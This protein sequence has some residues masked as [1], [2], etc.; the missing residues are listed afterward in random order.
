M[1]KKL[2]PTKR[3]FANKDSK[4]KTYSKDTNR[5]NNGLMN[6]KKVPT[7]KPGLNGANLAI[8]EAWCKVDGTPVTDL[9]AYTKD[10][11]SNVDKYTELEVFV[12]TDGMAVWTSKDTLLIK[13]MTVIVF[14][15]VGHGA[16]VIKR[17]EN[18]YLKRKG[19]NPDSITFEKLS[20]EANKS[21]ELALYLR[22]YAGIDVEMHMDLNP[23]PRHESNRVYA[24]VQGHGEGLGFKVKYKSLAHAA[25][26]CADYFL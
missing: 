3:E 13:L 8:H 2:T 15:K 24:A 11:V 19:A 12:G 25:S 20:M 1:A 14:W 22:E 6:E 16:H 10:Y 21:I 5:K 9:A 7:S 18:H 26:F 17:R 23:D 4:G